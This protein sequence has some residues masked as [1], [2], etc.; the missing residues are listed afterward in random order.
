MLPT[1]NG[2]WL[3]IVVVQIKAAAIKT[4]D[5]EIHWILP[6]SRH[7]NVIWL[8]LSMGYSLSRISHGEE[9]FVTDSDEFVSRADALA[10]ARASGQ[11]LEEHK[12]LADELGEL[13]SEFVW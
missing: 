2:G 7:H 8:L 1:V 3:E 11:L 4:A 5:G 9:G 6:P 10:I 13:Y 12:A